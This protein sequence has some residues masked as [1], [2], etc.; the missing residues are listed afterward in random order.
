MHIDATFN[1]IGP[2]L[3][4]ANPERPCLQIE[5]F[6]KAGWTIVHPPSPVVPDGKISGYYNAI[7][8]ALV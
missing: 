6:R 5:Q 8:P 4:L 7:A 3:V 1:I 2:G